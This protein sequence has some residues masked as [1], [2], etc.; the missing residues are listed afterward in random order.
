VPFTIETAVTLPET[1]EVLVR[2]VAEGAHGPE[3]W[4]WPPEAEGRGAALLLPGLSGSA[5]EAVALLD[6]DRSV[7]TWLVGVGRTESPGVESLRRA[8]GAAVRAAGRGRELALDLRALPPAVARA[9]RRAG[10]VLAEGLRLGSYRFDRYKSRPAAGVLERVVLIVPPVLEQ[11]VR[12]GVRRG[13]VVADAVAFARDLGNEP[14]GVLT[15]AELAGRAAAWGEAHGARVTVLDEDAIREARLGGLLAVARGSAEPPR[16]VELVY[17]PPA[18]ARAEGDPLPT[19]AL[20]GKG[21]TFDSGGLSLKTAD[22]MT[23]M[24]TDMCGAAAVVAAVGACGELGVG[25]RV[26]GLA[27]VTENMPGGRATKP[28]DVVT[29]RNG[30]TIEVLNTDAEGRLVLADALSLAAEREPDAIVDLATLTGACVVA[31][32]R[33]VAGLFA[34]HTGLLEELRR[35]GERAGEP[36]WPLPLPALYRDHVD[37]DVADMK[38]VGKAGQAG[39]IAAALLLER[40]SGGRPWA[41]L[42]IAGPARSEEQEGERSKGAT[43]FGVRTLLELLAGYRPLGGVAGEPVGGDLGSGRVAFEGGD[44]G[45]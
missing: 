17:E 20:V 32:G 9:P 26:V 30:A 7:A 24:K 39:A 25:V 16:L 27:P 13:E 29:A 36:L 8:A 11:A 37:S 22:A 34:N 6:A 40:F 5:G 12:E 3:P 43:G 42:D 44:D 45:S 1:V 15:P 33:R 14:A 21:I 19:V 28:G 4:G 2:F 41:H 35:A 10:Q 18:A 38:N 31:L 23:A